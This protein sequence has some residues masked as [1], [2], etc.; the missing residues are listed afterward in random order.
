MQK[1]AISYK[2][3]YKHLGITYRFQLPHRVSLCYLQEL[4]KYITYSD[5]LVWTS[6][7][8][9]ITVLVQLLF[10]GATSLGVYMYNYG[11]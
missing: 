3:L 10:I 9:Y 1:T 4:L 6:R 7:K 2:L 8:C 5:E 11:T